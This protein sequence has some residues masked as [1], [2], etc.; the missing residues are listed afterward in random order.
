MFLSNVAYSTSSAVQ[1]MKWVMRLLL[2]ATQIIGIVALYTTLFVI[3][4]PQ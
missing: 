2:A 4:E 3:Y 1:Q